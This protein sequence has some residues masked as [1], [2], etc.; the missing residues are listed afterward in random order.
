MGNAWAGHNNV[1][2][3]PNWKS[4]LEIFVEVGNLGE[5]WPTGSKNNVK[6]FYTITLSWIVLSHLPSITIFR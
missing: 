2:L 3:S 5:T 1:T 4:K 6:E